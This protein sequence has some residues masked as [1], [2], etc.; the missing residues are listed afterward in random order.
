MHNC[1]C[2][3]LSLQGNFGRL[4]QVLHSF[5]GVSTESASGIA[6][7]LKMH[8]FDEGD[9]AARR[10]HKDGTAGKARVLGYF[11]MLPQVEQRAA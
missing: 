3:R 6:Q 4:D 5:R 2:V 10:K 9:A 8:D 7:Q 1:A 11:H